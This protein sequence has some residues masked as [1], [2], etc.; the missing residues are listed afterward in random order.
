MWTNLIYL[1]YLDWY[2][3]NNMLMPI[4]SENVATFHL[5]I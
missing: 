4:F 2:L 1:G 3:E 5:N